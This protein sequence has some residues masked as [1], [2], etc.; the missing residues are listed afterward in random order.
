MTRRWSPTHML[1]YAL[2][3]ALIVYTLLP[4]ISMLTTALAPEGSTPRGLEWP[5]DPQW[6]NFGLAWREADLLPLLLSSSLI[7]VAVV[8]TSLVLATFAGYAFAFLR[9]PG[10]RVLYVGFLAGLTLPLEALITPLYYQARSLGTFESRWAIILPLVGLF[11][12]F[13]VFWMT[14]QFKSLTPELQQAAQLD[15]AS[16][17][18]TF[19]YVHLPV[20]RPGL[21]VLGILYFLWTWNQFL[22]A[23]VLVS[24][25][26]DRTM[27]G[28]LGTF[29]SQYG[30]NIVLLCAA[31]LIVMIPSLLIYLVFQRQFINALLQGGLK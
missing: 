10:R 28:A 11:M 6:G 1:Q 14:N 23:L 30:T 24:D 8:P 13:G 18:Q 29:Q 20:V 31:A 9:M 15:G 27:A 5:S 12:S 16:R 26:R 25:P 3:L 2:L 17:W 19:R 22:L 7:V 4:L 21:S